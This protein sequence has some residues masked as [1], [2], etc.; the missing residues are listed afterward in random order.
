MDPARELAQ[1]LDRELELEGG[2][3]RGFDRFAIPVAGLE[4][5]AQEPQRQGERNE[6][7]LRAIVQVA[8]EPS[9]FLVGRLDDPRARAP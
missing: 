9:S 8:L 3:V 4:P 1:L 6:P 7:L 2:L 5:L